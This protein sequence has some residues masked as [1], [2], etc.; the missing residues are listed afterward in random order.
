MH[1]TEIAMRNLAGV[2][3]PDTPLVASAMEH[4]RK[5][6]EPYLFNHV[7]RSWL[8]AAR[9]GQIRNIDQDL[10]DTRGKA[11]EFLITTAEG[12]KHELGHCLTPRKNGD[13]RVGS[14]ALRAAGRRD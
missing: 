7:V 14:V 8:F 11:Q 2:A 3:F 6:C 10:P 13:R 12:D 4:A 5:N 9:I 1:M